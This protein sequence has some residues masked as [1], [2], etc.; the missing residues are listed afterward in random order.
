VTDLDPASG[1]DITVTTLGSDT[2][3]FHIV[4]VAVDGP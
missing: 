2:S 3:T 1:A 4:E